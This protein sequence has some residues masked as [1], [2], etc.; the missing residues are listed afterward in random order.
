MSYG[1]FVKIMDKVGP[2]ANHLMFYFMGEPFLNREAYRMIRYARDMGIHVTSCTNG[3]PVEPL[4]LYES[5]INHISFQIGGVTQQSH[6]VYRRSSDLSRF[7]DNLT[8]L[9]RDRSEAWE[10]PSGTRGGAGPDRD[11][12]QRR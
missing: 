6:Q 2:R 3:D 11:A 9:S 10:A 12:P 8:V 1:D 4:A 7:F 5:G